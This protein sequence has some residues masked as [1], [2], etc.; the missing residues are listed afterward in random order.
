MRGRYLAICQTNTR[1]NWVCIKDGPASWGTLLIRA[2][3]MA[4]RSVSTTTLKVGFEA[5][6]A[7]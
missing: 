6:T 3:T 2:T 5:V 4:T 7:R 1:H